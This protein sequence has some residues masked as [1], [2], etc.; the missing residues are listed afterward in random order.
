MVKFFST[1]VENDF[2]ELQNGKQPNEENSVPI[3]INIKKSSK[4]IKIGKYIF[5][6]ETLTRASI[7]KLSKLGYKIKEITK[8]LK[9]SRML[10]WK[11]FNFKKYE[12]KGSRKPKFNS[13]EKE[14]LCNK[15]EGKI[16]GKDGASSRLLQKEFY[17]KFNKTIS[18]TTINT[19]LNE[20]LSKPLKIIN[21]FNLTK[22]HEEK[23]L[24]FSDFIINNKI[25]SENI[26]FTD[27][28]RV[29]LFPKLNKQNNFVRLN[30]EDKK[31]R[32]RPEIQKMRIN[33]TPKFE[34]S[35]MIAGG[36][37]KYGLSSL[38]FCS[39]TQNNFSYKQFLIFMKKDIEKIKKEHKLK[40]NFYFQQ[41]NAACHVS[42][43]SKSVI[44]ILFG[45]EYIEWPPNSPD[46]SPIENVWAILK[47]KLS[48]RNIKNLDELRDNILDIWSKFPISIC[49]K[50][51]EQF[52]EKIKH[53][54]EMGGKRINKELMDKIKADKKKNNDLFK[55]INNDEEWISVK[56]DNNYRIVYNDK[57]VK[58]I[59]SRF[60]RQIQ[61]QKVIKLELF[62]KENKKLKK[63]EKT[64]NELIVYDNNEKNEHEILSQN[65]YY[66]ENV[67][68]FLN[69]IEKGKIE[70]EKKK[71]RNRSTDKKNKESKTEYNRIIDQK[72]TI[73][74]EFYDNKINEITN[75]SLIDFIA[76]FLNK[77]NKDKIKSLM[78]V[79]L[80][81]NF[82]L[83]EASTAL[84][85]SFDNLKD[86]LDK[87]IEARIDKIFKRG[88]ENMVRKY[89]ECDMKIKD[90]FPYEQKKLRKDNKEEKI[91]EIEFGKKEILNVVDELSDLEEKIK[92]YEKE[93]KDKG[94]KIS[95]EMKD[96]DNENE[97]DE[98][99]DDESEDEQ[100]KEM[101]LE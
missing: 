23:R 71:P 48:K 30:K 25:S 68:K 76:N 28:C 35:I 80:S 62:H 67:F 91:N 94:A 4:N 44:D 81:T 93:N 26:F 64:N 101:E 82:S 15:V 74:E 56:R 14:F 10:A 9:I 95:I 89:I 55:P 85:T 13:N 47:E 52:N 73:I 8:I 60:I 1:I 20:G 18:H 57:I 66:D 70:S 98:A 83:N 3:D 63:G 38:I 97:V 33:E 96:S 65:K 39:G 41:D 49:E 45:K 79:N 40:D 53:V 92:E 86:E 11:W 78:N 90:F 87:E 24:K 88:R 43:E 75:M 84:S 99:E 36:I 16:T 42:R 50:L 51:I 19:I 21:T 7:V 17:Q 34:H 72:N 29:V 100:K 5:D 37:S 31:N 61:K 22:L 27:E 58:K 77:E 69:K 2:E 12:G 59:K 6:E 54:N 32:W 46:L